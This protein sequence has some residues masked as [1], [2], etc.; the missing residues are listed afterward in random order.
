MFRLAKEG[1]MERGEERRE[2]CAV[3]TAAASWHVRLEDPWL[4]AGAVAEPVGLFVARELLCGHIP[5]Q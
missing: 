2:R 3:S 4:A 1:R 5:V